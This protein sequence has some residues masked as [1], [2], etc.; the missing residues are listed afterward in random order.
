MVFRK[1]YFSILILV[2]LAVCIFSFSISENVQIIACDV[3]QGDAI[4]IQH[5][6]NQILIDGGQ[7]R[8]VLDCLG[9][10]MPFFDKQIEMIILTHPDIDHFGGLIDVFKNYEVLKFGTN[11]Q[12]VGTEGYRVLVN[13]VGGMGV[14]QL[15]LSKGMVIR[16]GLIYL[17]IVH[18]YTDPKIQKEQELKGD[19]NNQSIVVILNYAQFKALLTGDV[20]NFVSDMLSNNLKV[21]NV[22]YIKVNH[23]GSRNGLSENLLKAANPEIA[24]ISSGFKNRYGHPHAEILEILK[25]N[26]VSV[27]RTDEIGDVVIETDGQTFWQKDNSLFHFF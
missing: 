4:L 21:N 26:N 18:P 16:L 14:E 9:R 13:E 27:L 25:I 1:S 3:G 17:D 7:S 23:H 15:T 19:T 5:K 6:N 8:K 24:V 12:E 11:G 10:H 2:L 22:N 20:E